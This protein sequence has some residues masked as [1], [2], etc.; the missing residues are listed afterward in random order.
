MRYKMVTVKILMIV[1]FYCNNLSR[2]GFPPN[3]HKMQFIQ[4]KSMVWLIWQARTHR[5]FQGKPLLLIRI[6]RGN[7]D[8]VSNETVVLF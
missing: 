8:P 7:Y 4:G 5:L 1:S 6:L 2:L 3:A